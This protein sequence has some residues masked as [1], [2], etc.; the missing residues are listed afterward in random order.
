MAERYVCVHGHFYQPPRENP[1]LERVELQDSARPYHDWNERITAECYEPNGASRILDAENWIVRITNNYAHMSFD[2]GPTL[3][4]WLEESSPEAYERIL[5]ADRE[6][7]KRFSGHG[8]AMAQAYNHMILPL[9]NP[10]DRATQIRW[11]LADFRHRF[12]RE[13]EG[14][15]LP[16]TAVDIPSLELLAEQNIR[17]TLLAPDQARRIRPTGATE[18]SDVT[19]ARVDPTTAYRIPLPSGKSIAAFFY[20]GPVSHAIAFEKLLDDGNR[21]ADRLIGTFLPQG[22]SRRPW[23]QLVH[24]ATDGESYG[25]HHRHGDM[26]LA[27]ALDK[28]ESAGSA[29]LTNY[30]EYLDR[31]PPTFDAEIIENTSWSCA[32]G[33]ER[34][35]SNCGCSSGLHPGWSQTWRGPLRAALDFLRDALREP[36]ETKARTYL[37]DPWAAREAYIDVLLDSSEASRHAFL[38]KQAIWELTGDDRTTVWKLM[39]LQRHLQLMYTSCGWFFDEIS[40]IEAAQVLDYAGRALQLAEQLFGQSF[41]PEFLDRLKQAP[42]NIPEYGNGA[43]VFEKIVRPTVVDLYK[44]CAHYAVNSLFEPYGPTSKVYCYDVQ[45][46]E[47]VRERAGRVRLSVGVARVT[48]EVTF[49]SEVLTWGVV[50]F[51]DLNLSGGVRSFRGAEAYGELRREAE[52]RLNAGDIAGAVAIMST[53][54]DGLTYSL[55]SLFRDEQRRAVDEILRAEFAE[56]QHTLRRIYEANAPL[57]R[58]LVEQDIPLPKPFSTATEFTVNADLKNALDHVP[59]D[60]LEVTRALEEAKRWDIALDAPELGRSSQHLLE[61]LVQELTQDPLDVERVRQLADAVGMVRELPFPT[62]LGKAQNGAYALAQNLL[63]SQVQ[64]ASAGDENAH[65]WVEQ[66]RRAAERLQIRLP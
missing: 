33:V 61:R 45:S 5:E 22:D 37:H 26:A 24:I 43:Q 36:F 66:F 3:L 42:S 13:P 23:P 39:E 35:R 29:H 50:H 9:A 57:M 41:E 30:A 49:E 32:H 25:H 51:G 12:G 20:D 40:G 44:V 6:S 14:L 48:S 62:E 8:S 46:L 4:T 65:R 54:F 34:W 2:V 56:W 17:F 31:C 63:P 10:R 55:R 64:A 7:A 47:H 60:L 11:A 38:S 1:W 21:F 18:W 28:I 53:R 27:F 59:P 19:G 52:S 16:E 15:W 58:F